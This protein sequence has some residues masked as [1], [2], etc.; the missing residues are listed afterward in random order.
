MHG[1]K[2]FIFPGLVMQATYSYA[3]YHITHTAVCIAASGSNKTTTKKIVEA[4]AK[5]CSQV[6]EVVYGDSARSQGVLFSEQTKMMRFAGG[7]T[8]FV[9]TGCFL[10]C[11][12][13]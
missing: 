9:R 3:N 12:P 11:F 10:P 8:T 1:T 7:T 5:G 4:A 2:V 13:A 6:M